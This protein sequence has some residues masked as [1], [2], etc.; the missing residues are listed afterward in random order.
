ME[1]KRK[2]K[3]TSIVCNE[4]P[5]FESDGHDG[6]RVIFSLEEKVRK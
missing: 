3:W 6:K 1:R 4:R 2:M 5:I